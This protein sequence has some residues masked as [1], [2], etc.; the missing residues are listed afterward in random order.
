MRIEGEN[1]GGEEEEDDNKRVRDEGNGDGGVCGG[2]TYGNIF[3]EVSL[4]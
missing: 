2:T 3:L 4:G 1:D